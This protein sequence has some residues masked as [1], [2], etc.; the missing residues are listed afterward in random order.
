MEDAKSKVKAA[1]DAGASYVKTLRQFAMGDLPA[2]A[3]GNVVTL[4]RKVEDVNRLY[5][6]EILN[7]TPKKKKDDKK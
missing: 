3:T 2:R 1:M 6:A 7:P 5:F 4:I